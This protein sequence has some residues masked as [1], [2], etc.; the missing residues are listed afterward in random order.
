MTRTLYR[1]RTYE[2]DECNRQFPAFQALEDETVPG[3]PFCHPST[4]EVTGFP[5]VV[6][7]HA[8]RAGDYVWEM[9]QKDYGMS[10]MKDHQRAGEDAAFIPHQGPTTAEKD[11][12]MQQVSEVVQSI[13][14][15][16]AGF[17][18]AVAD[19]ARRNLTFK[20]AKPDWQGM[21][22][23]VKYAGPSE[24]AG[25]FNEIQKVAKGKQIGVPVG[26]YTG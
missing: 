12:Q 14:A 9:A 25:M 20:N 10:D 11:R 5:S 2:C 7:G 22:T 19:Q 24:G 1:K 13:S 18:Q 17:S 26:T 4:V 23:P 21:H 15:S 8:S 6:K 3:C 16:T